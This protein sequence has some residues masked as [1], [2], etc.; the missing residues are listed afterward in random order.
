MLD[1]KG[2]AMA[3][4]PKS[5][6]TN[7]NI[8]PCTVLMILIFL[9]VLTFPSSAHSSNKPE[10]LTGVYFPSTCLR[11]RSFEGILHYMEAAGLNLAV[12]HAK[13]PNGRLFWKSDNTT[14]KKIRASLPNPVFETAVNT[15]K[16]KGIWTA[17]K[18]DVF[19]DSLLVTNHPEMGIKDSETG[20]LW[21]DRKGLHWAN[22]Y[23]RRVWEYTIALSLELIEIGIDEI[24][25][26]YVRFPTDGDLSAIEY[27]V[28]LEDTSQE[29][30]IGKFLAYANSRLKPFGVIISIDIFGLTAWK[31]A[32]FGVGQVLE[33][34]IP[35]VDVI[36][37][38]L[39]PSHFP[40]NFLRLK[41]PGQ[42]PYRIVRSSLEEMKKRTE[43]EI[44]PWIQGFWY[45]PEEIIAQLQ[46]V[47]ESDI[48]SWTVWN[49]SGRYSQT[50]DALEIYA[51]TPFPE[52][53][54]YPLLED[55]R[56]QDDLV[57]PGRTRIINHT[58][59][60]EGYSIIS[61]DDS[62]EGEKNEFATI[63]GVLSTLD[64]SII[65]RI[66]ISRELAFSHWTSRYTKVKHITNLITKDLDADPCRMRPAPIYIDW[67]DEC[68][69]TRSIPLERLE[70][71][72]T[73]NEGR[74]TALDT[75]IRDKT[76]EKTTVHVTSSSLQSLVLFLL[77]WSDASAR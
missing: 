15:L 47:L 54:F 51:G 13:D 20:E 53:E 72:K 6:R 9:L 45:T 39:Y 68:I 5:T 2:T 25:F 16:Q 30:C 67:E 3:R 71:Y 43:K 66:L 48:Q 56:K 70:L 21:A 69:F 26:D 10:K 38:M 63:M 34:I 60:G 58:S 4:T 14:A 50:F 75:I 35:H 17:A 44:R 27:P 7:T 65:D 57:V 40:E 37:P 61:L 31:T 19:Q 73:H 18:L 32:D 8:D 28:I 64:E 42:Y 49:P 77:L 23:D 59:Y 1:L 36:C 12:L 74:V 52:P 24:Q 22:P 11:G 41:N 76:T 46:G 29:E 62:I 33:Q 55:L